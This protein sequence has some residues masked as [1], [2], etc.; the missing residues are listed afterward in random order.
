M[1]IIDAS[2]VFSG[3]VSAAGAVTYQTVTGTNTTVVGTNS[4]RHDRRLADR[5]EHR[6]RQGRGDGCR[7]AGRHGFAGAP[8]SR[9][10]HLGRRRGAH[11]QRDRARL[12]GRDPDR[13]PD[14]RQAGRAERAG[15]RPAHGPSLRRRRRKY[16]IVGAGSPARCSPLCS[17]ATATCRSRRTSRASPFS[18]GIVMPK[19]RFLS[20]RSSTTRCRRGRDR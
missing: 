18:K 3:A 20:S 16:V 15:R 11:D 10:V 8:R 13:Q 14:G 12:H 5:A 9:P 1:A 7:I 6:P 4:L 2:T 17:V 19:Y